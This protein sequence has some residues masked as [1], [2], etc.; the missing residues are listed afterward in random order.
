MPARSFRLPARS[1]GLLLHPTS[2]PGGHGIGDLGKTARRFVEFLRD[3]RQTWWQICPLGPLNVGN[4]PYQTL[5]VFAG[6]DLL[7]DL[8]QLGAKRLLTAAELRRTPDLREDVVDYWAATKF[9]TSRLRWAA[10]RFKSEAPAADRRRFRAFRRASRRWL[11]DYALFRAIKDARNGAPWWSWE[12]DARD[13]R[14]AALRALAKALAEDVF[15]YEFAQF[16]FDEQW[17][18]LRRFAAASNVRFLGDIP[19]YV[20]RDSA[21]VWSHRDLFELTDGGRL[22]TQ[23]GTPPDAFSATGQ[24][25]GNPTYRWKDRESAL[26]KWWTERLRR[27]GQ[28]F[29][30]VR[31]DHFIGFVRYWAVPGTAATAE[32]GRWRRGPGAEFFRALL[33]AVAPLAIIVEDLGHVTDDVVD[34]RRRFSLTGMRVLQYAF[35]TH[36]GADVNRPFRYDTDTVVYTGT[37]DN[38]TAHSWFESLKGKKGAERR[39]FLDYAGPYPEEPHWK[40]IRLASR[41]CAKIAIVPVQDVLGH[42][43][44]ARMNRPGTA[45]DNWTWRLRQRDLAAAPVERLAALTTIYGRAVGA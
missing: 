32:R 24:L 40:L 14:P 28:R 2:L 44:R 21:D 45:W 38:A 41:S 9:K 19:L 3:G 12:P 26:L 18:S 6:N 43:D 25:W 4:S 39:L 31:L 5:S 16:V 17:A 13:R 11:P 33:A 20:A 35:E 37:H 8:E 30:A 1:S 36:R 10:D 42:D 29:D 7:I 15:F 34:I 23:A 22:K 27:A